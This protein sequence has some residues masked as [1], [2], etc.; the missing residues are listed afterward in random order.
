MKKIISLILAAVAAGSFAFA[1]A[2]VYADTSSEDVC[3]KW[4]SQIGEKDP[5]YDILCGGSSNSEE[6]ATKRIGNILNTVF[7]WVGIIAVIAIIV[8]GILYATS[9]GDKTKIVRAKGTIIYA[10]IGLLVT[11]LSFAIVNFILDNVK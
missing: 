6:D 4:E 3:K 8:G 9:Q 2:A 1:P 10:I 7:F 11:L 5:N